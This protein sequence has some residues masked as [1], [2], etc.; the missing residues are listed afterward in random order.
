MKNEDVDE[1]KLAKGEYCQKGI[2]NC[3][4]KVG[5]PIERTCP[6]CRDLRSSPFDGYCVCPPNDDICPPGLKETV[7]KILSSIKNEEEWTSLN[8]KVKK[9]NGELYF[10]EVVIK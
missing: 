6:K 7:E 8:C 9:I 5:W 4:C 3:F 2:P 10:K 1:E